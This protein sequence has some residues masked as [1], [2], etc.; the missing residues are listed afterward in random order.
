MTENN[1]PDFDLKRH[2]AIIRKRR[3]PAILVALIIASIFT[4][5][6]FIWPKS[7]EA[8]STVFIERGSL[9]APLLEGVGVSSGMDE[10]LLNLSDGIRSR[11]IIDRVIK[12]LDLDAGIQT[13]D[14]Y[15]GL[16]KNIRQNLSVALTTDR[17]GRSIDRFK[18]SYTGRDPKTVR[19]L[20]NTIV[21]EYINENLKYTRTDAYEVY[22]FIKGQLM[23]Y[24][25][26]LEGSDGSI[27]AFREKNPNMIPQS[28]ATI[29]ARVDK[30]Q[31]DRIAAEISLKELM[32]KSENLRKQ[33]S[34]EK[35]LTVAFVSKEGSPQDKLN[36]LNSR[37]MLLMTKYT[38]N[39]PAVIKLKAEIEA[40]K[41]E[42]ARQSTNSRK[43]LSLDDMSTE[44][45]AMNP[46]YQSLKEDLAKTDADIESLK[47]R[48]SELLRQQ[49]IAQGILGRM[50]REQEE[51][52][53][54]QRDRNV[55]QKIYDSLLVKLQNAQVSKDIQLSNKA[56]TFRVVDP[57]YL[58][59]YPV[60]PNMIKMIM[61]GIFLG[62]A[63]G[64]ALSYV[65]ESLAGTFKDETS[66]ENRFKIP[67]LASIPEILT[68]TDKLKIKRRDRKVFAAAGFYLV[69]I[70]VALA[71]EVLYRYMGIKLI[72]F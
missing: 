24:K 50:P 15:D 40:L 53:K 29:L 67:V 16:V 28:E 57:A 33:L 25:K 20:V 12:E 44:T 69:V 3:Y 72:N 2:L 68:E 63:S 35:E 26:K 18:V 1:P 64:V 5:G 7:Y 37:L 61:L 10:R 36:Y 19:D 13:P 60:K 66:I 51:W 11:N 31:T 65:L 49:K 59:L 71:G 38:D 23:D 14:Q 30:F 55:Y 52:A 17:T 42:I 70:L 46:I 39:Y 58:P 32:K 48:A 47:E 21:K 8:S 41:R 27:R 56:A 34:G 45:S 6:S 4:W 43:D 22:D 62:I 9:M 54:L